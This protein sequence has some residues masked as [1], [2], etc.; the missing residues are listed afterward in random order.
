[1]GNVILLS[2]YASLKNNNKD[3]P[4]ERGGYNVTLSEHPS[5]AFSHHPLAFS[6]PPL[7]GVPFVPLRLCER[8][9]AVPHSL[10]PIYDIRYP[11]GNAAPPL[12]LRVSARESGQR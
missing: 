3:A 6:N 8:L 11:S 4:T 12:R 9:K 7:R 1:M 5:S 2:R 10:Y